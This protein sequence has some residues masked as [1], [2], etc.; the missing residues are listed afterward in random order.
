MT[1]ITSDSTPE[2]M[3]QAA[4]TEARNSQTPYGSV[5]VKAGQ[6]VARAGNSVLQRHDPTAHAELDAIRQLTEQLQSSCLEKGYTLYTTYEPC[7]MCAAACVW[8]GITEIVY[9]AGAEDF[10]R[11][12]SPTVIQMRCQEVLD[13]SPNPITLRTGVLTSACKQLHQE[14]P[15]LT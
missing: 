13:R 10:D 3:M 14:F 12:S 9:G 15:L 6:I 5:I 2:A 8:A 1:P 11:D 4:I 7:P